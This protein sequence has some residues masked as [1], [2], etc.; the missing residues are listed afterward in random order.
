MDWQNLKQSLFY[1]LPAV[2]CAYIAW[3]L[4]KG[5]KKPT[6]T[7]YKVIRAPKPE[8]GGKKKRVCAIL[9]GTGFVGSHVVD[10][11][12]RRREYHVYMLGRKFRPER[13]NPA[14]D[15]L[16]QVDMQ[17]FDGLVKAFQGVDSVID[18]A[19]A[20]PTVFTSVDDIWRI[21]QQGLKNVVKAAQQAGVR[22]FVFIS[23]L[24]VTGEMRDK[25]LK[26]FLDSFF[27]GEKYV[28]DSNG[29]EGMQ[30]CAILPG[31]IIGLRSEHIESL[32]SGKMTSFPMIEHPSNF[33]PVEYVARAVANAEEKLAVGCEDVAGKS[34]P[35]MGEAMS[36]KQF[37]SLPTWPH[38][39]SSMPMLALRLLARVNF[40]CAKLTGIAP[41]GIE[42]TPTIVAFFDMAAE[43]TNEP[44]NTREILELGQPQPMEECIQELARRYIAQP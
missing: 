2:V 3:K 29:E 30:T 10:E 31:N 21:N 5:K 44:T 27:W 33:I 16:I 41:L 37:F 17:D 11:F 39:I 32:I 23:G 36:Y 8:V 25:H 13:T 12:V 26:A 20:I 7:P 34:L 22:N 4:W 1:A 19:A 40:V 15:A 14:T 43:N 6:V 35:L 38:K 42:L 9:G 18:V 24:H 28:T